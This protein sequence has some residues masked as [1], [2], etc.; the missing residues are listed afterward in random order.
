MI[1]SILEF[2]H[3]CL[4]IEA[5]PVITRF[6]VR[7]LATSHWFDL[8]AA[9]RD[10]GYAPSVSFEEGMRRLQASLSPDQNKNEVTI[11]R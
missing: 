7:E 3:T 1:A 9:R 5:E 2:T 6:V 8:T 10:L 11:Q 4:R